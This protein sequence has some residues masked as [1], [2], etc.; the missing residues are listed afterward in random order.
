MSAGP[1]R[2]R[3]L[4]HNRAPQNRG[5]LEPC[6][7]EAT[8]NNPLCGDRVT[9]RLTFSGGRVDDARFEARGCAI[10][11]ASASILTDRI[12]R[13]EVDGAA[14][15]ARRVITAVGSGA[16]PEEGWH[17]D[18][19]ALADLHRHRA[20]RRCATLPWETLIAALEPQ[21]SPEADQRE[22]GKARED[23]DPVGPS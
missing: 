14:A 12:R 8:C 16:P 5:P 18:L 21:L 19:H 11:V 22:D 1:Y 13:C 10:A 20:R 9:L 7:A 6:D 15:L 2:E 3:L 17:A 23:V 4:A